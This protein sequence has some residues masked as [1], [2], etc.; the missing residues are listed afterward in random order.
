MP[1]SA[2]AHVHHARRRERQ[3]EPD[4]LANG[5]REEPR[6]ILGATLMGCRGKVQKA[7]GVIH[8]IVERVTDL[9]ADL[10]R[11]SGIDMAF[12]MVPS[13]GDEA[14]TG[15]SGGD[16]REPKQPMTKPRDMYVPDL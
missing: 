15:G 14:K 11:V 12:P 10:K 1:G 4:R 13:R 5:V 7:N 8:L 16:S 3:R 6:P 2:K 9:S